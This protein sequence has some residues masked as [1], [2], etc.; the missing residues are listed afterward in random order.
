MQPEPL[1]RQLP[2][3]NPLEEAV[4]A[5]SPRERLD[6]L[7]REHANRVR[8][9]GDL[10]APLVLRV[11]QPH[12]GDDERDVGLDSAHEILLTGL[13]VEEDAEHAVARLGQRGHGVEAL[14]G[15]RESVAVAAHG[16]RIEDRSARNAGL[17]VFGQ[18]CARIQCTDETVDVLGHA[19][20][21]KPLQV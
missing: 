12:H 3:G 2:A 1:G 13:R 17:K 14:D 7:R 16:K 19:R 5:D 21:L 15:G 9:R 18:D 6:A 4:H 11:C 20:V 10:A 8:D